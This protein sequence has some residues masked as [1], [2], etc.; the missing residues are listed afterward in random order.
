MHLCR[1]GGF[2][3]HLANMYYYPKLI[4]KEEIFDL[5]NNCPQNVGCGLDAD[6]PPYLDHTW[7]FN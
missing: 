2:K 6:C 1:D 3:G 7:W 4:D 5:V